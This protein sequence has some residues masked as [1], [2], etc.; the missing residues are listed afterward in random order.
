MRWFIDKDFW[1]L[2]LGAYAAGAF[3]MVALI[4]ASEHG[5]YWEVGL[6]TGIIYNW[7]IVRTRN[8]ADYR[9]ARDH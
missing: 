9:G 2:P 6:A 8:L 3:W 4:F 1:K 5:P 7:W